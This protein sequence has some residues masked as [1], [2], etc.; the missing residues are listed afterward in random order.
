MTSAFSWQN[1]VNF[2]PAYFYTP[3]PKIP[4][5][6]GIFSLPTF[7]FQSPIMKGTSFLPVNSRRSCRS[8]Q[9]AFHSRFFNIT[10][11]AIVL[12]Y[13]DNEWLALEVS[14]DHSVIFENAS[15]YCILD[16]FVDYDGYPTSS[17]GFLNT[18]LDIM[19]I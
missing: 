5:T 14:R 2:C 10:G 6:P 19:V 1:P 3:R 18:I 8:S 9:K 11:Q 15:K 17:K 12:D 4:I 7:A 16:P 13:C